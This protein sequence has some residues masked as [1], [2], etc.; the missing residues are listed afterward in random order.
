[1]LPE[2]WVYFAW[3]FDMLLTFGILKFHSMHTDDFYMYEGNLIIR[4]YF[5]SLEFNHA[6]LASLLTTF[7]IVSFVYVL[8]YLNPNLSYIVLGFYY[9]ICLI[10]IQHLIENRHLILS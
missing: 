2:Y 7:I 5:K 8:F 4:K 6:C 3:S 10:H 1:M 9:I